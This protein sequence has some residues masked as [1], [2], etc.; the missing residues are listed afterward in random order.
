VEASQVIELDRERSVGEILRL[1]LAMYWRYPLL[2]AILAFGVIAPYELLRLAVTGVGPLGADGSGSSGVRF[3]FDLLSFSLVGP[4]IS[5]LH[6]HA[7]IVIGEGRRPNLTNVARQ[8]LRVLL[9]VAAAEIAANLLIGL[10]FIAFVI[11]GVLLTLRWSVVAQTAAVDHEGWLPALRRSARLSSGNYGHIFGLLFVVWVVTFGLD[12]TVRSL[13]A[14]GISI[15]RIGGTF[16]SL[17]NGTGVGAVL[18]G[19]VVHTITASL[20]ALTLAILYFDLRACENSEHVR[21]RPGIDT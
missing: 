11:P 7:V 4:L 5:A 21:V 19:I 16:A 20:G 12:L 18:V 1:T 10:G 3:V 14:H 2:F 9:V 6:I 17:H 13:F 15:A 8:G